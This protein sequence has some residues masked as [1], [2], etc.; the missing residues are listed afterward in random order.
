M[1]FEDAGG[2]GLVLV[3]GARGHGGVRKCEE[4]PF[5]DYFRDLKKIK[6]CPW[7]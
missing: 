1:S 5:G 3:K 7:C 6:D 4:K 2:R